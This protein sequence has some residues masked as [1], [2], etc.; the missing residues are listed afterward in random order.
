M[1]TACSGQESRAT[2]II[3]P[4]NSLTPLIPIPFAVGFIY[5]L[6]VGPFLLKNTRYSFIYLFICGKKT[7]QFTSLY[8]DHTYTFNWGEVL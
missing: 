3:P 6:R 1:G 2:R 8:D 4:S 5:G 7:I